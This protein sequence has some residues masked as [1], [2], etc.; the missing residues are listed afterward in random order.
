MRASQCVHCDAQPQLEQAVADLSDDAPN[1][2][3]Y[4]AHVALAQI[5]LGANDILSAGK[6]LDA[7]L[8]LNSGYFPALALQAKIVL[9]NGEPDRALGL[10]QPL[11][12]EPGAVTPSVQLTL[13][14]ALVSRKGATAQDKADATA[15]L[16][17]I[18]D[19]I[20]PPSD[21]GRVAAMIDPKLPEK[22]GVP[23]DDAAK[24]QPKKPNKR[25]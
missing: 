7:A 24:P 9:R 2:L 20:D 3:A 18:K 14:E 1:P 13:A 6:H 11:M 4:R 17:Q 15:L 21:V 10:L 23:A 8:A 19:K 16:E 5:A 22:L 12:K 25:K